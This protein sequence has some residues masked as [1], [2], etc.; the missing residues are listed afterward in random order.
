MYRAVPVEFR[1]HLG[2]KG[3]EIYF[4]TRPVTRMDDLRHLSDQKPSGYSKDQT[5]AK[6]AAMVTMRATPLDPHPHAVMAVGG[7]SKTYGSGSVN[8]S[9]H[10][11]AHAIDFTSGHPSHSA[12]FAALHEQVTGKF[13][14]TPYYVQAN[15]PAQGRAEFFAE[16]FAAWAVNRNFGNRE[17]MAGNIMTAVG[18]TPFRYGTGKELSSPAKMSEAL[19][20]Q[21]KLGE[22]LAAYYDKLY[23]D[24]IKGTG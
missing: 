19:A 12:E 3:A 8:V 22:Q 17:Q 7:G 6:V 10:E 15:D 2:A 11:A 4:G 9:A 16:A 1:E 14:V 20:A 13:M 21:L 5:F 23:Q 18:A 24:F